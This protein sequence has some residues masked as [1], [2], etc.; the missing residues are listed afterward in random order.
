M[1]RFQR[2]QR[3]RREAGF[4]NAS[5]AARRFGWN[6]NNYRSHENGQRGFKPDS[7]EKYADAF[8]VRPEWLY[9]DKGPMREGQQASP[10]ELAARI[11]QLDPKIQR[12]IDRMIREG[13]DGKL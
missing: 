8:G 13:I 9:F 10:D 2:L 12:M 7:A 3:A 5:E 6:E 1:E 11:R 4:D